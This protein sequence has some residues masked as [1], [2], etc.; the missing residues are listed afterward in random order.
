MKQLSFA[1]I[2]VSAIMLTSCNQGQAGFPDTINTSKT[3]SLHRVKGTRLFVQTPPSYLPM[4]SMLRLQRDNNTYFQVV[5][6]PDANFNE[7][8]TKMT[9]E[10]IESQGAKVDI[11]KPVKY[12][13]YD[14]L[15]FSGPSKNDGETKLGFIF[16]DDS[17][18]E[19]LM[20]VCKTAD[21]AAIAELNK[22][23]STSYYDKSFDLNPMELVD[24]SFDE[25]I[26]GFKY[27]TKMGSIY[28]YTPNGAA[29]VNSKPESTS[30]LQLTEI[31]SPGLATAKSFFENTMSGYRKQDII[32]TN[33]RRQDMTVNGNPAYEVTMSAEDADGKKSDLYQLIMQ[34]GEKAVLFMGVDIEQGKWLEKFKATAQTLK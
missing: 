22:I 24:F 17:F 1:A 25:S 20:G 6:M 15:Y 16:G 5:D 4:E 27:A 21:K 32:L 9:K 18:V 8:K 10:A 23:F 30:L 2:I 14:A 26:T 29:D 13:G 3:A 28:V 11:G 7:Y 19:V 33:V 31:A 34:K 12:N